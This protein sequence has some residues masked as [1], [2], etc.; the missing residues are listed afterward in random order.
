LPKFRAKGVRVFRQ[1]ERPEQHRTYGA[2]IWALMGFLGLTLLVGLAGASVTLPNVRTW[3][4]VLPHPIGTPP[5]W[6]FGPV[7]TVLYVMMAVAA[8]MVWRS[9][10]IPVRQRRAL[11]LWGW[12][13]AANALWSPVFFGLHRPP[14]ALFVILVL[15]GLIVATIAAFRPISRI[16]AGMM[17]P[18]L[19][20]CV[21]A[22]YLTAG[23]WFLN[24]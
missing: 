14:L 12:Q 3:Y 5:D 11:S 8:W 15:D 23:F 1:P 17:L 22:T 7:W 19:V 18:Y 16:A 6:V 13:L 20:W 9:P 2:Q 4:A 24:H 21:F 10:D